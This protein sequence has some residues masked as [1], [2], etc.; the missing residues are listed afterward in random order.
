MVL[1]RLAEAAVALLEWFG[2]VSQPSDRL[3]KTCSTQ[4]H[5]FQFEPIELIQDLPVIS[6][7][8]VY[9]I[10]RQYRLYSTGPHT[11]SDDRK[12]VWSGTGVYSG[13]IPLI[14]T[15]APV[16]DFSENNKVLLKSKDSEAPVFLKILIGTESDISRDNDTEPS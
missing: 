12:T 8:K 14:T 9:S 5:I 7:D 2:L 10:K 11:R 16:E 15:L 3:D 6:E 13:L 4:L 1:A